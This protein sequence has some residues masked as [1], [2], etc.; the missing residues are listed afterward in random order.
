MATRNR[1]QRT[2]LHRAANEGD[3]AAVKALLAAGHDPN[4]QDSQGWSPLHFAAQASSAATVEALLAAGACVDPRDLN[5]NTPL[6]RAVFNSKGDG[7]VILLL[8]A[9]GA[10]PLVENGSGMSPLSLAR[11]IANYDV[12]RF[13]V[14]FAEG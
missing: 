3:A 6:S 2:E 8:R 11:S 13:F 9:A 12:N 7:S 14:D 10:D 4:S 1:D 5:G